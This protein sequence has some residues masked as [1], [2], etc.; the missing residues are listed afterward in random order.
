MPL[1]SAWEA[2]P[3]PTPLDGERDRSRRLIFALAAADRTLEALSP[4]LKRALGHERR[5]LDR[6][7]RIVRSEVELACRLA[8]E[9]SE[10]LD[11]ARAA[12]P[13][14]DAPYPDGGRPR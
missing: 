7:P 11:R 2:E 10:R 5:P 8:G 4:A 6:R 9:L 1:A 12:L 13:K 3:L 14:P